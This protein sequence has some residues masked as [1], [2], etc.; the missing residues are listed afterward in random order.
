MASEPDPE[1]DF[2]NVAGFGFVN[3]GDALNVEH[4]YEFEKLF[5][6]RILMLRLSLVILK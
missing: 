2:Q 5:S 6:L 1:P 3:E 4:H